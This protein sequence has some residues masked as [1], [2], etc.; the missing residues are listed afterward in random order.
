[1]LE[2]SISLVDELRA[3]LQDVRIGL[4]QRRDEV[5]TWDELAVKLEVCEEFGR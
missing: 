5:L 3:E 4:A 2:R 1:M